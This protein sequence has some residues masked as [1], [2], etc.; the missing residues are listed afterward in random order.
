MGRE[1][2]E[3]ERRP[4]DSPRRPVERTERVQQVSVPW[5]LQH[6]LRAWLRGAWLRGEIGEAWD[7]EVSRA[8][9]FARVTVL[10]LRDPRPRWPRLLAGVLAAVGVSALLAALLWQ[11][12][13]VLLAGATLAGVVVTVV[14]GVAGG[15]GGCAGV[16]VHCP[17]GQHR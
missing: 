16:T 12:R 13:W 1:W 11:S 9:N 5:V 10:R 17:P 6:Q 2:R 8:Q 4:L 15:Q 14:R 7:W 3:M